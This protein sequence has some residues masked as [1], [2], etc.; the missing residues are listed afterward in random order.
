[1]PGLPAPLTEGKGAKA[2]QTEIESI[3][4]NAADKGYCLEDYAA[5]NV[6]VT[7]LSASD[8]IKNENL[9]LIVDKMQ[10]ILNGEAPVSGERLIRK[11]LRA[12]GIHRLG[13]QTQEATERAMEKISAKTSRQNGIKFYWRMDQEPDLYRLYRKDGHSGDRRAMNEICLQE[14]KNAVC[15][16]LAERGAQDRDG[17]IKAVI[18]TMGYARSSA[19]LASA[20]EAGIK[21]GCKTGEIVQDEEKRFILKKR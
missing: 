21:Y 12:F 14:L 19:A 3:E 5:A 11:T 13:A 18:R 15:I 9:V 4:E 16:T 8:Y 10:Q 1:M 6:A 17:L 7:A 2:D 20:V